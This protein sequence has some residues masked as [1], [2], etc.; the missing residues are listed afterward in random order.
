MALSEFSTKDKGMVLA[1]FAHQCYQ[2][3]EQLF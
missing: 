3:P 2:P 1:L